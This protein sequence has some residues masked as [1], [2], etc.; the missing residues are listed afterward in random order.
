MPV[1][2]EDIA[3]AGKAEHVRKGINNCARI[4]KEKKIVLV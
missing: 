2:L 4:Q 3:K 1:F